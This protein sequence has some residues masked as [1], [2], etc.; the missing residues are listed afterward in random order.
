MIILAFSQTSLC[1]E[2]NCHLSRLS[3]FHVFTPDEDRDIGFGDWGGDGLAAVVVNARAIVGPAAF[4]LGE[5]GLPF[6]HVGFC[7]RTDQILRP[8]HIL[9]FLLQSLWVAMAVAQESM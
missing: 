5:I 1:S 2:C 6:R 7:H 4:I 8:K 3:L 9:I